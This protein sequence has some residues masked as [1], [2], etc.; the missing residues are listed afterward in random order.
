MTT[1]E[2]SARDRRTWQEELT[3]T[4]ED[5]MDRVKSLVQEGNIRK[6]II[7]QEDRTLVEIPLSLGVVGALL[8]PQLAAVGAIAALVTRCTITVEHEGGPAGDSTDS[9]HTTPDPETP[10]SGI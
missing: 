2:D 1:Q 4:G 3:A 5:L 10:T 8:A 9:S 6:L 7:K